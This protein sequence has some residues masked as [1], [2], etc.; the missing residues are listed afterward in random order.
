MGFQNR[1]IRD[2]KENENV[3]RRSTI[4]PFFGFS[5]NTD[6]TTSTGSVWKKDDTH[7]EGGYYIH[8][9]DKH[10]YVEFVRNGDSPNQKLEDQFVRLL[11][12]KYGDIWQTPYISLSVKEYFHNSATSII[13]MLLFIGGFLCAIPALIF[14]FTKAYLSFWLML[15]IGVVMIVIGA[16]I[17]EIWRNWKVKR[18]SDAEIKGYQQKYLDDMVNVYGQEMGAILQKIAIDLGRNKWH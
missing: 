12:N 8:G 1:Y 6:Y 7:R 11:N 18:L 9:T 13:G 10:Y 4:L 17:D 15:L 5:L 3:N 16:G 2:I 14:L